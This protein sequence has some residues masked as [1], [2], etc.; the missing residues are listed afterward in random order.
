MAHEQ[1]LSDLRE[2]E[3]VTW[4]RNVARLRPHLP[5]RIK[6]LEGEHPCI[7]E[8]LSQTGARIIL[9]DEH[10]FGS[11][12]ILRCGMLDIFF[13]RVWANHGRAGLAFDEIVAPETLYELRRVHD[14]FDELQRSDIRRMAHD[15]VNGLIA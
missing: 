12:G 9:A 8:D 13:E 4:R 5:G 10:S 11:S 14:N 1:T 7:V 2:A 15:S 6:T 3:V